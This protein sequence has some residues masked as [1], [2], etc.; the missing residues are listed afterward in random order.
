[1]A[2]ETPS[3]MAGDLLGQLR[4]LRCEPGLVFGSQPAGPLGHHHGGDRVVSEEVGEPLLDLGGFSTA[5]EVRSLVVDRDFIDPSEIRA[6]ESGN[7]EP[8]E[9]HDEP[10]HGSNPAS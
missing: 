8:R 3:G 9:C 4:G 1:M 10:D 2:G 6:T 7:S 5:G